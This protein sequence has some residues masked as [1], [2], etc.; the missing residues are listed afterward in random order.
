MA[1]ACVQSRAPNVHS[2]STMLIRAATHLVCRL[3]TFA[4]LMVGVELMT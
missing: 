3:V 1:F 4:T 2:L